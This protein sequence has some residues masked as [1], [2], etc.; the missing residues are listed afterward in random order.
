MVGCVRARS[1]LALGRPAPALAA[2][3]Q[4]LSEQT[5]TGLD[6]E[7]ELF[8]VRAEALLASGDRAGARAASEKA[9]AIVQDVARSI[10]DGALKR[11]FLQDVDACRRALSLFTELQR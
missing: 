10:D 3:E 4:A 5:S 7:I 2:I 1:M 8:T 11:S 6:S 9:H